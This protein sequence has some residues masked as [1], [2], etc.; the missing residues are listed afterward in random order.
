M[1]F[2]LD[3]KKESDPYA[4][5]DAETFE[6]TQ[7]DFLSS[8]PESE[9][10]IS[11]CTELNE[12]TVRTWRDLFKDC[13]FFNC[14]EERVNEILAAATDLEGWYWWTCFPGCLPESEP[15]GPF[16]T[17]EDAIENAREDI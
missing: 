8:D 5:S 3:P 12:S 16:E 14:F 10:F 1:Y 17:E 7:Q 9:D 11:L 2:Y 6:L 15:F 4:Q 13:E